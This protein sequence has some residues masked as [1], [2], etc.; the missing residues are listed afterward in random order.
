MADSTGK[1]V[2]PNKVHGAVNQ[3]Q[4]IKESKEGRFRRLAQQRTTAALKRIGYLRSLGNR[5]QYDFTAEQA[6]KIVGAL[7]EEVNTVKAALSEK[8]AAAKT[9]TL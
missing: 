1:A 8:G 3:V 6:E 2:T 9:F 7:Q 4:K 5:A